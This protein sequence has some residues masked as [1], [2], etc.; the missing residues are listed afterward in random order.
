MKSPIGEVA[1]LAALVAGLVS[2]GLLLFRQNGDLLLAA[3]VA[4]FGLAAWLI[5]AKQLMPN[6]R[7]REWGLPAVFTI[8]ILPFV[9]R[10]LP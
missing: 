4:L 8:L 7:W 10:L 9:S 3:P 6:H 2:A 5:A 1:L